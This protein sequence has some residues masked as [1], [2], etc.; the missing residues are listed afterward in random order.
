MAWTNGATVPPVAEPRR[1][2]GETGR[3]RRDL[4]A[5]TPGGCSVPD[6]FGLEAD[7]ASI[8]LDPARSW[9]SEDGELSTRSAYDES[10]FVIALYGELDLSNATTVERLLSHAQATDVEEIVLD[11][12]GLHFIDSTGIRL[13][14]VAH[15]GDVERR[16]R[17]IPGPENVHRVFTLCGVDETLP[18]IG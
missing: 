3:E 10:T 6:E 18:F 13:V 15:Q 17:V 4:K 11:L 2:L 9:L 12:S 5:L 14:C 1:G 7:M 8:P 16:L